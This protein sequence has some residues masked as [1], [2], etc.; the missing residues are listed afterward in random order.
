ML[1]QLWTTGPSTRI[2]RGKAKYDDA[3]WSLRHFKSEKNFG[4]GSER[5]PIMYAIVTGTSKVNLKPWCCWLFSIHGSL[6]TTGCCKSELRYLKHWFC[7]L[8]PGLVKPILGH[9]F[10]R[11]WYMRLFHTQRTS[12]LL[13]TRLW[14]HNF[15]SGYI[16]IPGKNLRAPSRALWIPHSPN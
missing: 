6:L 9:S 2:V 1:T 13:T 7:L 15:C 12:F 11:S 16:F 5:I 8:C 10:S 14:K 3:R 4:R